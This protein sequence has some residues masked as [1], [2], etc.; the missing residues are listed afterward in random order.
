MKILKYGLQLVATLF[1]AFH[2]FLIKMSPPEEVRQSASV[3]IASFILFIVFLFIAFLARGKGTG[4][5]YRIWMCVVA[6]GCVVLGTIF[7]FTYQGKTYRLTFPYPPG[8]QQLYVKGEVLTGEAKEWSINHP[9]ETVSELVAS[10]GGVSFK[11]RV[12]THDSIG[13]AEMELTEFYVLFVVILTSAVLCLLE[14]LL[15]L[16]D[17]PMH[18]P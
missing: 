13:K 10:F 17:A 18:T 8:G 16:S 2:G 9:G 4:A 11:D 7:F 1:A 12:W 3:G 15:T 6:L 5:K 14:G